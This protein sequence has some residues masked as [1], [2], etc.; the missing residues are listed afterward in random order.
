M[1]AWEDDTRADYKR[2]GLAVRMGFGKRPA[3]LVVDFIIGFTDPASPLGGDLS[4]EVAVTADLLEAFRRARRPVVFTT[5]AYDRDLRDA[6]MWI[7]KVP[8]LKI[9]RR[10]TRMVEI[11]HRIPPQ[12]GEYVVEKKFA[13]AFFGTDLDDY[14]KGLGVD[15][16]VMV[17]CTTSGCI[18]SSAIDAIQSGYY[19]IVV[20]D[21]VGDRAAGPHEANLFDIDAKYGDVVSSAEVRDYL[22]SFTASGGLA[23]E[24]RDEFDRWWNPPSQAEG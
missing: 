13:S 18:R 8:S 2:K 24:A 11:D 9:L 19:S 6:G 5:I 21:A 10:G 23:R 17:G 22:R 3:L 12:A 14:L 4:E 1:A 20:S 15:T 16:I 7:K